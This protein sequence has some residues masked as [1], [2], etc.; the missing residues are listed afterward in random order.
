MRKNSFWII[1]LL[2]AALWLTP[3]EILAQEKKMLKSMAGSWT[4]SLNV[5]GGKLRLDMNVSLNEADSLI[6]TFDSP[7]QGVLDLPTSRVLLMEDSLVV[8]AEAIGGILAGK[9]NKTAD[10]IKGAWKQGGMSFPVTMIRQQQ[11]AMMN[12]PQEPKPPFPYL[13]EEVSFPSKAGGFQFSGTLTL[14][15][16]KGRYPAVILL[17]GSG[18]QNRDEE[19]L[20]HKPFLVLADHLT[21]RGFAVLR[22]DDRG[23][24]KS[25]GDY[26]TATT[27]DF[28]ADAE[29]ALRFLRSDLRIDT[30][31]TGLIGHSEGG[32][33]ASIVASEN[34]AVA[35]VVL[36]AGPGITGEKILLMQSE[37]IAKAEGVDD[38][39]IK[40]NE[41]TS[42]EMY[43][44]IR[45]NTDNARASLKLRN[46]F[47]KMNRTN[48]RDTVSRQ[49][50]EQE[51][52]LQIETL[53]SPWFRSFLTLDPEDYISR[54]K[55]P[56]LAINGSLDLQV[57]ARENLQAIEKALI[58]GGNADYTVEE[59]PGLNHLFQTATTG[60]PTEYARIEETIA[61][62][63]LEKIIEWM[64]VKIK[65]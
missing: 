24:G 25:E 40:A 55:C 50:S 28:A 7:D 56:L 22:Y 12:R 58:F 42:R 14:P 51:I 46:L 64:T 57:P 38:Q 36:M 13:V 34:P 54:V 32:L 65:N 35:F 21:R 59:L 17:T 19:L 60:S 4:G 52:D 37:L 45:K 39:Q 16:N 62:A 5:G 11:R 61:P 47:M 8:S 15:E 33:I 63:A 49:L 29:A 10:S 20:G 9:I 2:T 18:A 3:F 48:A 44:V 31:R 43:T 53:T 1:P 23:T 6:V 30:A 41:K 27:L 26:K